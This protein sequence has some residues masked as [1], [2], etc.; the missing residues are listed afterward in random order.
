MRLRIN[1]D[2]SQNEITK[3]IADV[4]EKAK[5]LKQAT[6]RLNWYLD[7]YPEG[8]LIEIEEEKPSECESEGGESAE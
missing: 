7:E 4:I 5:A 6:L 2:E 8:K 3:A 1:F